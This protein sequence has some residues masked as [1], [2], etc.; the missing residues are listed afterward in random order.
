[1]ALFPGFVNPSIS[2]PEISTYLTTG[3]K[4]TKRK[5]AGPPT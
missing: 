3:K 4:A 2:P 5:K 1:M